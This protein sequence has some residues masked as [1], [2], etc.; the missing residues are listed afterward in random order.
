GR[1]YRVVGGSWSGPLDATWSQMVGDR[2]WNTVDFPALYACLSLNVARAVTRDLL[3]Y[4]GIELS[5]LQPA[6]RPR[7]VEIGW[8]GELVDV[9]TARGGAAA[10]VPERDPAGGG[11]SAPPRPAPR[12]A[13]PGRGGGPPP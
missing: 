4:S 12:R 6:Y 8:A 13:R 11:P 7:L 9:A 3:G 2:R 10:G 5:D 1:F